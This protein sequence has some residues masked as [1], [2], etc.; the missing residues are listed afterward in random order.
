MM[1]QRCERCERPLAHDPDGNYD[2]RICCCPPTTPYYKTKGATMKRI[3]ETN[4]GGYDAM[5][6]EKIV[7]FCGVYIYTGKLV[8]VNDDHLEL[9]D[10]QLVYE[11]GALATGPWKDAQDLPGRWRVTKHG[12]ESWGA[13]KC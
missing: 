1:T 5:L 6:G 9:D 10:A 13:A 11:T 12:V 7:L 3:V 4:D 2:H 8:G